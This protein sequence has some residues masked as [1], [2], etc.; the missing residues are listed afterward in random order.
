MSKPNIKIMQGFSIPAIQHSHSFAVIFL[1]FL[2][3]S[4][5]SKRLMNYNEWFQYTVLCI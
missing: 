5:T 3:A 4:S 1:E 2:P